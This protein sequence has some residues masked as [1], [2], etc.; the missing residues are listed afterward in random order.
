MSKP[1]NPT[2]EELS[3]EAALA[4]L[5]QVVAALEG[6][7]LELEESI[8]RYQRGVELLRSLQGKLADAQQKVTM[9]IGELE[10]EAAEQPTVPAERSGGTAGDEGIPF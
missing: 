8:E 2:A 4:E 1:T 9:L 10:A 7:Q 6:G 3:F 5:D